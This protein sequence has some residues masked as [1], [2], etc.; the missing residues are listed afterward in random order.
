MLPLSEKESMGE[1]A[2]HLESIAVPTLP[3]L[4]VVRTEI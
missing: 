1:L 2:V 3:A 4:S